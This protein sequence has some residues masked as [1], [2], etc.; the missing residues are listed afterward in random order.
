MRLTNQNFAGGLVLIALGAV[1]LWQGADLSAGSLRQIGPGFVPRVLAV[2]TALC[3][4]ALVVSAL[5]GRGAMMERW[6]V[7]GNLFV[8]A[9]IIAF[10]FTVRP[11]GL[12]VAGPLTLAISVFATRETRWVEA[13]V[14]GA[15]LVLFCIV[16]FKFL[17]RLP[18]PLAPWAVGY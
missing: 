16:L 15:A 12:V 10:G 4:V 13:G 18:V 17:L 3:G 11:L 1:A 14:F 9:A 8:L 5:I 2:A 6:S 7:R